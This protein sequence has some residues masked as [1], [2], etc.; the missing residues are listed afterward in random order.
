MSFHSSIGELELRCSSHKLEPVLSM[1]ISLV[2]SSHKSD[3]ALPPKSTAAPDLL[4]LCRGRDY[5]I[6]LQVF[7]DSKPAN[8]S[9]T[10]HLYDNI[11]NS[12][13]REG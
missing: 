10:K 9:I 13:V 8:N 3:E 12:E 6:V 2:G 11:L 1:S 5:K 4:W 7:I